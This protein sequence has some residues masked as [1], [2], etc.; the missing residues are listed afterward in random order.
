VRVRWVRQLWVAC[1]APPLPPTPAR[2]LLLLLA[3]LA[4]T[5]AGEG[6][7]SRRC[8]AAGRLVVG[9]RN[10]SPGRCPMH[11]GSLD[12]LL[13]HSSDDSC[14]VCPLCRQ[15]SDP[16]VGRVTPKRTT[17][18][19]ARPPVR[20]HAPRAG[21][22]R[23]A[24]P[25]LPAV[26]PRAKRA[27]ATSH[28]RGWAATVAPCKP[29]TAAADNQRR[30]PTSPVR[31]GRARAHGCPEAAEPLLAGPCRTWASSGSVGCVSASGLRVRPWR[32]PGPGRPRGLR[33]GPRP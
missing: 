6:V 30:R 28:G 13:G 21:L 25:Q 18:T 27:T 2:G 7:G 4:A 31:P 23:P 5:R 9:W 10:D 19:A 8:R 12:L 15:G 14:R 20:P 32:R 22:R 1:M 17:P 24:R 26:G 29:P 16:K 11:F 33:R 3:S